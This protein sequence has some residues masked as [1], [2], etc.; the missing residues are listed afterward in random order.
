WELGGL[1]A[2]AELNLRKWAHM[3]GFR[4]HFLTK[5]RHW[6][7]TLTE[8]RA[9]RSRYR[10]AE[11]LAELEVA[12]DEVIVVNDWEAVAFGHASDAERELAAAIADTMLQQRINKQHNKKGTSS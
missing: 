2:Y 3:L 6:S 10:L 1:E 11:A 5:S 12:E 8:L 4:G 7:T 9:I